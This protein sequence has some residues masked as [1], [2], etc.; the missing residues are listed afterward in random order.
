[1]KIPSIV[2]LCILIFTSVLYADP[3]EVLVVDTAKTGNREKIKEFEKAAAKFNALQQKG[4]SAAKP[5]FNVLQM[6]N[7]RTYFVFGFKDQVQGVHP[8]NYPGTFRNL[9]RL[10][11]EGA[12]M[13]P[14]MRWVSVEKIRRLMVAPFPFESQA[15]D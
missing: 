2:S 8:E 10:K 1:M 14:N 11:N 6:A 9:R 13:Y 15:E 5:Y 7:G 12:Q 4:Y 3:Y